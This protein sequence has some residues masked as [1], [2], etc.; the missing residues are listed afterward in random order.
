VIHIRK[1]FAYPY[2]I[3]MRKF[4]KFSTRYP[5]VPEGDTG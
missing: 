1:I 3:L 5:C 2:P 4:R